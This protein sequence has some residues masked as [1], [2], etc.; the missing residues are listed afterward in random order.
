MDRKIN[1]ISGCY[2]EI[3]LVYEKAEANAGIGKALSDLEEMALREGRSCCGLVKY[4]GETLTPERYDSLPEIDREQVLQT[5]GRAGLAKFATIFSPPT[6]TVT[7]SPMIPHLLGCTMF[8][9]LNRLEKLDGSINE[10]FSDITLLIQAPL[11]GKTGLMKCEMLIMQLYPWLHIHEESTN[12]IAVSANELPSAVPQEHKETASDEKPVNVKAP[13]RSEDT[14]VVRNRD[15][16]IREINDRANGIRVYCAEPEK[17]TGLFQ[18]LFGKKKK[19]PEE[20]DTKQPAADTPPKK[21]VVDTTPAK[22]AAVTTHA[23]SAEAVLQNE[24][25]RF[26]RLAAEK[27]RSRPVTNE[28]LFKCFATH[29]APNKTFY[30]SLNSPESN[31][32]FTAIKMAMLEIFTNPELFYRATGR[33]KDELTKMIEN[34]EPMI[35]MYICGFIYYTGAY[36]TIRDRVWCVDFSEKIPYCVALYLLL[37]AQHDPQ[38]QRK[39]LVDAGDRTYKVPLR[40]AVS[41]LKILDPAWEC[42]I[43]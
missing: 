36:A 22:P 28:E 37:T 31:A 14:I 13:E 16:S 42:I 9:V 34:K 12:Q 41:A 24:A 2:D 27:D 39:Q 23:S 33:T 26:D 19:K 32:Y 8:N 4:N 6:I 5:L 18:R 25:K 35:N 3:E 1:W 15:G 38:N 21:S 17:K 29:F 43:L 7:L 11:G 40:C 30:S 10:L 20:E